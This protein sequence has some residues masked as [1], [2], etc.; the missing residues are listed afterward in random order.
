MEI[1]KKLAVCS[2]ILSLLLTGCNNRKEKDTADVP[3][4][5]EETV[6]DDSYAVYLPSFSEMKDNKANQEPNTPKEIPFIL[7]GAELVAKR[8]YSD[9]IKDDHYMSLYNK[10]YYE[11]AEESIRLQY[12]SLGNFINYSLEESS[13]RTYEQIAQDY[14]GATTPLTQDECVQKCFDLLNDN[15]IDT[16]GFKA[17]E[18]TFDEEKQIYN[19]KLQGYI[20]DIPTME[21]AEFKVTD[22]GLV[23][24]YSGEYVGNTPYYEENPFDMK[25]VRYEVMQGA[26]RLLIPG[27]DFKREY[28]ELEIKILDYKFYCVPDK[29]IALYFDVTAYLYDN[30][31][32]VPDRVSG[33]W[34]MTLVVHF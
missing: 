21:V 29:G 24:S 1:I 19:V 17:E 23:Y 34:I 13:R 20:E 27:E 28:D 16:R 26:H 15:S 31:G 33:S 14:L 6:V 12:N 11:C 7:C 8:Q 3:P 5:Q 25:K 18:V 30:S 9:P 2:L 22:F 32:E 4:K 10:Y